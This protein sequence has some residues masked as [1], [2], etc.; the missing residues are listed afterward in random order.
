[1]TKYG[2][3]W[4]GKEW[5]KVLD[6]N[7]FG[8]RLTRGRIYALNGAVD[9]LNI[10]GNRIT[11]EV[12][13]GRKA[14]YNIKIDVSTLR[15]GQR[16]TLIE[17]I[18]NNPDLLSKILNKEFPAELNTLALK[19]NIHLFPKTSNDFSMSCNCPDWKTPCK[20]QAA[21]IYVLANKLDEN[22]FML[23]DL[24]NLDIIKQLTSN[25]A[26][27][28]DVGQ[29]MKLGIL[30][31]EPNAKAKPIP[32][33]TEIESIDLSIIPQLG[34]KIVSL[35]RPDP[36]F[37]N[38]DFKE[39]LLQ[40]YQKGLLETGNNAITELSTLN[41]LIRYNKIKINL[42]YWLEFVNIEL[43]NE[44]RNDDIVF[45]NLKDFIKHL[46][47]LED[48]HLEKCS[49][50]IIFL[51]KVRLF[52]MELLTKSAILPQVI[53]LEENSYIIRWIPAC[54]EK[55]VNEI[56][57]SLKDL[58]PD[59][60]ITVRARNPINGGDLEF[61]N[62][63][64]HLCSLFLG[65]YIQQRASAIPDMNMSST[66][67][68]FF[69][70]PKHAFFNK[71]ENK[72]IPIEIG[73]W[74]SIFNLSKNNY[75]PVIMV[76]EH[77]DGFEISVLVQSKS[78]KTNLPIELA[79]FLT[80]PQ[81]KNESIELLN[82]LE[83]IK[84]YFEELEIIISSHG[85]KN[86]ILSNVSFTAVITTIIPLINLLGVT[87]LL[88]KQLKTIVKPQLSLSI[89]SQAGYN[90]GQSLLGLD[91]VLNYN[92]QISI[93]DE[94][95]NPQ[96][97][98]NLVDGL[99]GLVKIN[100]QYVLIDQGDINAMFENLDTNKVLT[101]NDL[102]KIALS[103][104]YDGKRV[105]LEPQVVS[106]LHDLMKVDK[107]DLP[108]KL[109]AI[110]R[111]YQIKGFEWLVKNAQL[112]LG[113]IIADDMGLGKTIQ[114]IS[115]LLHFKHQNLLEHKKALIIVP[116]SLLTNWEKEIERFA[117]SLSVHVFHG[118]DRSFNFENK[119]VVITSFGMV[120]NEV[121]LEQTKWYAIVVDEAQNIKNNN[122]TQTKAIK[123][124][125]ADVKIA[126]TGTPVE[127][128]LSEYWSIFDFINK[129]YLGSYKYFSTEFARPIHDSHNEEKIDIFKK[130]TAPFIMR[131]LK[132]DK[133]VISDL[134]EKIES[135]QYSN[136]TTEQAALY[137]KMVNETIQQI[138]T[139]KGIERKGLVLKLLTTLKQIGNH[140]YQYLK[141]GELK[142]EASGKLQLLLNI[143]DNIDD[144]N[145]KTIIFTQYK[146]MGKLLQQFIQQHQGENP[147]FLHGGTT[148]KE[149]DE[150][151]DLFQNSKSHK[152]FILSLKAGGNGLNLTKATNV[153]HYDLWWNPAVENQATDRA[154]RIGQKSNVMVYRLI[155][156]GTI[157][158]KID[159]MHTNK[160]ELANLTVASGETWIGDLS[161]Q[162]LELLIR[163]E[164]DQE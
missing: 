36:L 134:P 70:T 98:Y 72:E 7:D 6:K 146:E 141:Q 137:Q 2:Q 154:Y 29:I 113:S 78:D 99:S 57:I 91:T 125:K 128:R 140:P 162:E 100:D 73:Q 53:D 84:Q 119:D 22:P 24:H 112:G 104:Q 16:L 149:R 71:F 63:F 4:C 20:H 115:A 5:L 130:I 21:V 87:I 156:K 160:K 65:Y 3:T 110:L 1:M 61:S 55:I 151:V 131:R 18:K 120:R 75:A 17:I 41:P 139:T 132:S 62:P 136:L 31:T 79:Q 32:L 164:A 45:L 101:N 33:L 111:P 116:T 38:Y 50:E 124:I 94:T 35:L 43:Y 96:Q 143:L 153:I 145:E 77:P 152:V 15:E 48:K 51:R 155:N 90:I 13:G 88:P 68:Q 25:I 142:P 58:C 117:P 150:M 126:M 28:E 118:Q 158:E 49:I 44:G 76:T 109:K 47:L 39:I 122:T 86:I 10:R 114:V 30:L 135:N 159:E 66:I 37:C 92:W 133:N 69:F 138:E 129:G 108:G 106:M 85:K 95:I 81:F 163:L 127:N 123:K 60:F 46:V 74:L 54:N 52:C 67:S 9:S 64:N 82:D 8:L 23:F 42:N 161:T 11:A 121:K 83:L 102:F 34:D 27:R 26:Q 56:A 148:R 89:K 19:H 157:E 105:K 107:I 12:K 93:G 59:N 97:F 80:A 40:V 14:P 144:N 147:L 103:E